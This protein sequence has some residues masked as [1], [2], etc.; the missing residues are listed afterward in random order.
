VLRS[1]KVPFGSKTKQRNM[2]TFKLNIAQ[3]DKELFDGEVVSLT[4]PSEEGEMT[5]LANHTAIISRLKKG[6]IT[7]K[8][9]D[10]STQSIDID[11]GVFEFSDNKANLML[12]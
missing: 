2:K 4:V 12:F 3:I 6:T 10:D 8:L 7:F 1:L 5:I 9:Q 11:A